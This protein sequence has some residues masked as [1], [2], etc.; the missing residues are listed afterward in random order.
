MNRGVTDSA[1]LSSVFNSKAIKTEADMK[2]GV[3][4][5]SYGN[6]KFLRGGK[7]L[8]IEWADGSKDS[9]G[10]EMKRKARRAVADDAREK[11]RAAVK[12]TLVQKSPR[13]P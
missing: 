3:R 6:T 11:R 13:A 1:T 10:A 4:K 9:H 8:R 2:I 12:A 5:D 7:I